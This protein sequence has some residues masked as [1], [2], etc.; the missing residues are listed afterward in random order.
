MDSLTGIEQVMADGDPTARE[1][2]YVRWRER[3]EGLR[4][5]REVDELVSFC[6]NPDGGPPEVK[7]GAL[8]ALCLEAA[9][10]DREASLLLLW[11]LLP[12][13]LLL[14]AS[15]ARW[16]ALDPEELD[17][18]MLAGVWETATEMTPDTGDVAARLV[19]AARRRATRAMRDAIEWS[20]RARPLPPEVA[21][22][23]AEET[24]ETP[25]PEPTRIVAQAV[26]D[27]AISS[28][29][30][31]L[32]LTARGTLR[33]L[34]AR[35]GITY[36]AARRRRVRA[37]KRLLAWVRETSRIPPAGHL[38]KASRDN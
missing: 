29:E 3:R 30:A 7:D 1:S 21:E 34:G 2:A 18:E 36:P 13:L 26:R 19:N 35:L 17:A 38:P 6:R 27:G 33:E 37:R 9:G 11:L 23:T 31:D 8:A 25:L 20:R 15:L 28:E 32:L 16:G 4:P 10:G 5:F 22:P 14:R 12:A 24:E